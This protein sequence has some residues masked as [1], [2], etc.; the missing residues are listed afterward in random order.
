MDSIIKNTSLNNIFN[1]SDNIIRVVGNYEQPWF[2]GK[3]IASILGYANTRDAVTKNVDNEDKIT[4]ESLK[5]RVKLGATP[6]NSQPHSVWINESGLYS[7]IFGSKL[8]GAKKFKRWVTSEVLPSI[9]KKGQYIYCQRIKELENENKELENKINVLEKKRVLSTQKHIKL[10]DRLI[11]QHR[12]I[13]RAEYSYISYTRENTLFNRLV[14][15]K[16]PD[17]GKFKSFLLQLSKTI[18]KEMKKYTN[19]LPNIT[20]KNRSNLYTQEMYEDFIDEIIVDFITLR[21]KESLDID[22]DWECHNND[23]NEESMDSDIEV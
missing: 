4:L 22:W 12:Y 2:N 21:P 1:Y 20:F 13:S 23:Y 16:H 8:E 14:K 19:K 6:L 3:D 10:S 5:E 17:Y 7:L 11:D 15:F 18:A 9:R